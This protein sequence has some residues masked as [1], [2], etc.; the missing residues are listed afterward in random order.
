VGRMPV[1]GMALSNA[2]MQKAYRDRLKAK[3]TLIAAERAAIKAEAD[4]YLPRSRPPRS[5][6]R[7]LRPAHFAPTVRPGAM[8]TPSALMMTPA[9][10]ALVGWLPAPTIVSAADA[11]LASKQCHG[12]RRAAAMTSKHRLISTSSTSI[13]SS[14]ACSSSFLVVRRSTAWRRPAFSA[15]SSSTSAAICG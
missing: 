5:L 8:A 4:Q 2:Q 15:R 6:P 12:N 1:R 3:A 14:S 9:P 10:T 11:L 7:E 13:S